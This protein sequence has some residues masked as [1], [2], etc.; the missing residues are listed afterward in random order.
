MKSVFTAPCDLTEGTLCGRAERG[1]FGGRA[2]QMVCGRC[3]V[4]ILQFCFEKIRRQLG[5]RKREINNPQA[6]AMAFGDRSRAGFYQTSWV[7]FG[8]HT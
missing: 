7:T 2:G 5:N 3:G 8:L 6:K 1:R 4:W